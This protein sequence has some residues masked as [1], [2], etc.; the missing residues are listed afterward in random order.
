LPG[1]APILG[2]KP[3]LTDPSDGIHWARTLQRSEFIVTAR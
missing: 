1:G 2:G 3:Q